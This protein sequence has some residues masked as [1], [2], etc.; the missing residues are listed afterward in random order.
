MRTNDGTAVGV[1]FIL[2]M[3]TGFMM[4]MSFMK[5]SM[6]RD[7]IAAGVAEW[8]TNKETGEAKFQYKQPVEKTT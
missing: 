2:I 1:A 7:A 4:G 3:I 5:D 6:R 8:V